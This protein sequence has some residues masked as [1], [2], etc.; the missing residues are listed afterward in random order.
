M[1]NTLIKFVRGFQEICSMA[2]PATL[3][4]VFTIG[5][6]GNAQN[7]ENIL[8]IVKKEAE[9]STFLAAVNK[10]G[11]EGVLTSTGPNTVFAPTNE[12]FSKLPEGALEKLLLDEN[13]SILEKILLNHVVARDLNSMQVIDAGSFDTQSTRNVIVSQRDNSVFLN[14]TSRLVRVDFDANNGY[15]HMINEILIPK[16]DAEVVGFLAVMPENT[17]RTGGITTNTLIWFL[18]ILALLGATFS[19]SGKR[20]SVIL[21][22]E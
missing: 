9:L 11:L 14:E 12:A 6:V 22:F 8:E 2:L 19:F 13:K 1:N 10:V 18:P 4:L 7:S 15:V 3:I 5:V 21:G 16:E 20:E 17:P